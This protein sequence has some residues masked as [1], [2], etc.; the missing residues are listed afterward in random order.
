MIPS[1]VAAELGRQ[2]GSDLPPSWRLA[3]MENA[4]VHDREV[5][6]LVPIGF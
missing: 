3:Q 6:K 2:D 5:P 4:R 1:I